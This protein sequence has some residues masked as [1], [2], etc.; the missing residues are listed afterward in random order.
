M[1]RKPHIAQMQTWLRFKSITMAMMPRIEADAWR[2]HRSHVA[3]ACT[4]GD[5][6]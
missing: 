4:S 6:Q 3:D 5:I 2:I 1:L